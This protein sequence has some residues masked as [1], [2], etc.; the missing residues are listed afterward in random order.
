MNRDWIDIAYLLTAVSFM[1]ALKLMNGPK[2]A[3][4]GNMLAAAGMVLTLAVTF[5]LPDMANFEWIA[6]A[7]VVGSVI[8]VWSARKVQMTAMPQMVALFNGL[9]GGAAA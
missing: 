7:F 1:L 9:G 4:H 5:F 6:L 8:G 2:S 3:R